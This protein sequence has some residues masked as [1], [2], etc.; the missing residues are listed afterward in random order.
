VGFGLRDR[1]LSGHRNGQVSERADRQAR[2]KT[3]PKQKLTAQLTL[4]RVL[5][6]VFFIAGILLVC[7]T[8]LSAIRTVVVPRGEKVVLTRLFFLFMRRFF[9][10]GSSRFT[11]YEARDAVLARFAPTTLMSLPIIWAFGVIAGFGCMFWGIGVRPLG[12]AFALSGSSITTLGFRNAEEFPALV[13]AVIE[14]LIGLGLVALMISFLPTMHTM[15]RERETL[16][17]LWNIRAG[18][19][20]EVGAVIRRFHEVD[21]LSRMDEIWEQWERWFVINEESHLSYPSLVFFRSPTPYQSWITTAG[22]VL[23][24]A[25]F[26]EA[27]VDVPPSPR[28]RLCLRSGYVALRRITDYFNIAYDHNPK[29]DS[30]ISITRREF[31]QLWEEMEEAGIPLVEDQGQAW[32]DFA[33]WRVNYDVPL[34]TLCVVVDAPYA[35]WSSDLIEDFKGFRLFRT[36]R[37]KRVEFR[38]IGRHILTGK[39]FRRRKTSQQKS[40]EN[41]G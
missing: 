3:N 2:S 8:M 38:F 39:A 40:N 35:K 32:K 17:S 11:S 26:V 20:P 5:H 36:S 13:L 29:P 41:D 21:F 25:A 6:I 12:D 27:A 24:T 33:G 15:F 7:A 30:P 23:D 18:S 9:I 37:T 4:M 34:R 1:R 31:D 22:N 10:F 16:C 19:P 14:G 28:A